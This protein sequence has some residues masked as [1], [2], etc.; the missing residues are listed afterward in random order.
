MVASLY[1]YKTH[2]VPPKESVVLPLVLFVVLVLL[3]MLGLDFVQED[4]NATEQT[5]S[6]RKIF[7][8]MAC[9]KLSLTNVVKESA[10]LMP[11]IIK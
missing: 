9:Y 8:F 4:N 10:S 2:F 3:F 5:K 11:R 6:S 1:W 7:V